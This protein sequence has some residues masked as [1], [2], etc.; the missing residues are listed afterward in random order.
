L[1]GTLLLT[2]SDIRQVVAWP[3]LFDAVRDG[4]LLRAKGQTALPVSGQIAMPNALLHLK[5]GAIFDPGALSVKANLRPTGGHAS[6]VVVLYDTDA[7]QIS[8][9]LDSADITAMRTAALATVAAEALASPG[10][11]HLAVLG[12]GPLAAQVLAALP[13][14]LEIASLHLWSRARARAEALAQRVDMPV[15]IY[16]T[17]GEAA[18]QANII[19]TATPARTPYL[20]ASDITEGALILA[21]GADSPGKRELAA[22]VLEA[23]QIIAD[24]REDVL[25]VGESAY[26]PAEGAHRIVAELGTL[27]AGGPPIPAPAAQ[28]ARFRVFDS[29]G[30]AIIDATVS[31]SIV[32][33]AKENGF[34]QV[35]DFGR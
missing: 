34:G 16:D 3:V 21:M 2:R 31:R 6:G 1:A 32:S 22:S 18:R 33:L 24:Q 19:V 12:A 9:I 27:L 15:S 13:Q 17:P 5:A 25:K 26:L 23:A 14:R 8:A 10:P 11:V 35:F 4:L 7:G 20:E 29:V 30:S 28:G